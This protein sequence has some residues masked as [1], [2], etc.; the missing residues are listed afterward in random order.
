MP[1][2]PR[3]RQRR[4]ITEPEH[5]DWRLSKTNEL[6]ILSSSISTAWRKETNMGN[7]QKHLL[8]AF[9][10]PEEQELHRIVKATSERMDVVKRARALL[11]VQAGRPFTEAARE[12]GYK[13]GDSIS[14]LVERFNARGL[15]ALFIAPGRGRK[16][17]Y[18]DDQRVCI[19]AEAQRQPDPKVDQT[20]TWSLMLLRQALRKNGLP[21]IAKETIRVVLQ[22]AGYQ[23]GKTRTWCPTGTAVRKRKAGLIQVEDPQ[24]QKKK[25]S[26]NWPMSTQKPQACLYGVKMKPDPTRPF[27]SR[28]RTGI[29]QAS[30]PC[31][32]TNM[33]AEARL[34]Y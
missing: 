2:L 33:Y 13:S 26:L 3:T 25:R 23:F 16:P 10:P 34:S 19:I 4:R 31:T 7:A 27:R 6:T 18:T 1:S 12:A 29:L 14:Q 15:A 17:I 11:C 24:A 9:T 5:E 21:H 32:L 30:R 22:D 8:R 28:G 20:A